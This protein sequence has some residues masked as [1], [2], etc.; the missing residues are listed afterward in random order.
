[1]G[2]DGDVEGGLFFL[3]FFNHRIRSLPTYPAYH[4][5]IKLGIA[6]LEGPVGVV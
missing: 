4:T 1:M 6:N 3:L 2:G 5:L